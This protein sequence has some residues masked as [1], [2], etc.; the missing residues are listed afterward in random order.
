M[1]IGYDPV[2]LKWTYYGEYTG[3][4]LTTHPVRPAIIEELRYFNSRVRELDDAPK[5]MH[6]QS[7]KC[8]RTRWV[9]STKAGRENPYVRARL[10]TCEIHTLRT[11][12]FAACT[13]L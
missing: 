4:A 5:A 2:Q 3:E 11:A 8:I 12:M 6:D 1:N 9:I 10:A 7:T 13:P